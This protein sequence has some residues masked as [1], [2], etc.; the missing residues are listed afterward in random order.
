MSESAVA[1]T[2]PKVPVEWSEHGVRIQSMDEA[3]RFSQAVVKSGFVP[4]GLKTP[5][6]VMIA[7]Q[8]GMELGLTPW[9]SVQ[10][11]VPINRTPTV[12]VETACALVEGAGLLEPGTKFRHRYEGAGDA[13]KCIV[14]TTP[15]GA[16]EPVETE[17]S[18][19][20]AKTAGLA[21]KDNWKNYP[22][23]MLLARAKGYHVRDYYPTAI[24]RMPFMEERLDIEDARGERPMR[25]VS[26]SERHVS[27]VLQAKL[28]PAAEPEACAHPEGF[29]EDGSGTRVCIMCGSA[30]QPELP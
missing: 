17:F 10:S 26:P 14:W 19:G 9:Q 11:I 24:R 25:D 16:R 29:A 4:D 8:A 28:E 12:R 1:T 6:A 20:D 23:R 15:R 13:L 18:M 3:W 21:G 22:Q 7:L 2:Q 5:E 30:E 27:K